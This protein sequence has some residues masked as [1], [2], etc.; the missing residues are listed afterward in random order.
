[1][2]DPRFLY[3]YIFIIS[4]YFV[5]MEYYIILYKIVIT[6]CYIVLRYV[7][8]TVLKFNEFNIKKCRA[9][10]IHESAVRSGKLSIVLTDNNYVKNTVDTIC[11]HERYAISRI[12]GFVNSLEKSDI[13][14]I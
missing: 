12:Q 5:N 14:R 2:K 9:V 10:S 11:I 7:M 13:R 3:L 8:S 1:M 6:S 4:Q